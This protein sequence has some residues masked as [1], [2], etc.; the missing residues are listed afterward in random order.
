MDLL[1]HEADGWWKHCVAY[2]GMDDRAAFKRW[3][4]HNQIDTSMFAV[5]SPNRS[6]PEVIR[7]LA[8]RERL[9]EFAVEAQGLGAVAL[10]ERFR[11]AF[12][13]IAR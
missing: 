7:S 6:A 4:K 8:L 5:A 11:H 10:Q 1:P 12:A 9:L 2:P 3:I 13:D